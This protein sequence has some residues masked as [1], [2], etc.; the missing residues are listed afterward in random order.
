[1]LISNRITTLAAAAFTASFIALGSAAP[2][3]AQ[4]GYAPGATHR[5]H[6]RT[7]SH[8]RGREAFGMATQSSSGFADSNSPAA[9]G[10]GSIGYNRKLLEY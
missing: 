4:S 10:G 6:D 5:H 1:M 3:Y 8:N 2:A 9:T 7:A